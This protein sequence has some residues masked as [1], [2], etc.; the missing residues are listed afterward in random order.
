MI[1]VIINYDAI[2]PAKILFYSTLAGMLIY[3]AETGESGVFFFIFG[4]G[5]AEFFLEQFGEIACR[6]EA[7]H[8]DN[9]PD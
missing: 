7:A 8:Q 9:I 1:P 2:M 3:R 5:H 6:F 4:W